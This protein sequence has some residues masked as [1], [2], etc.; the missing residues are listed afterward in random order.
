MINTKKLYVSSTI[1]RTIIG[2]LISNSTII[3]SVKKLTNKD[4][5]IL[6][7]LILITK[8]SS[9]ITL[10]VTKANSVNHTKFLEKM[11]PIQIT[12]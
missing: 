6:T 9:C 11:H 10:A 5:L 12:K 4:A 3:L 1:L 8:S 7:V 2:G